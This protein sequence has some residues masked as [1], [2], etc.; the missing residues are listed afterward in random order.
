MGK[1]LKYG[2]AEKTRVIGEQLS[3]SNSRHPIRRDKTL[4]GWQ[5]AG[6]G[7]G[8]MFQFIYM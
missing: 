1:T 7:E 3:E 5:F 6:G 8:Q 4:V 2:Y